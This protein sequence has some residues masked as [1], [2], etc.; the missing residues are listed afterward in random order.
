MI[1]WMDGVDKQIN[2]GEALQDP[3]SDGLLSGRGRTQSASIEIK[4]PIVGGLLPE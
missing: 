4:D 2:H 3:Q 1:K